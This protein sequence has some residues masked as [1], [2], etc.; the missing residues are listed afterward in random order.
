MYAKCQLIAFDALHATVRTC[1]HFRTQKKS[2]IGARAQDL[3][4]RTVYSKC[5]RGGQKNILL[6]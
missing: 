1:A 5:Q 2:H 3:R 6:A 4:R